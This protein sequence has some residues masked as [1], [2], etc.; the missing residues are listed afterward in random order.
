[1]GKLVALRLAERYRVRGVVRSAASVRDF[2]PAS[3]ELFE[4]DVV[5]G[6]SSGLEQALA[7]VNGVVVCTGT[8]AFPTKAWAKSPEEGGLIP[9]LIR[10]L[11]SSQARVAS[12]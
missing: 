9:A 12:S 7:G 11:A 4:T 3:V 6:E 8:T 1:M 2:L 5:R 10:A